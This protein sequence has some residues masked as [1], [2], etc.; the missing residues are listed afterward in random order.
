MDKNFFFVELLNVNPDLASMLP[1]AMHMMLPYN[2]LNLQQIQIPP[3]FQIVPS[4]QLGDGFTL[5]QLQQQM[6]QQQ[7][8]QNQQAEKFRTEFI[9]DRKRPFPDHG[10]FSDAGS[11][12]L[13]EMKKMHSDFGKWV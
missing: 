9:R 7:Q 5:S 13:N 10:A 4:G 6:M 3:G 2:N 12:D 1:S 8:H 11:E